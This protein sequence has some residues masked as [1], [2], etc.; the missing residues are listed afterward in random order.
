[1]FSGLPLR[2]LSRT[3]TSSAPAAS[4]PTAAAA[5]SAVIRILPDA[6]MRKSEDLVRIDNTRDSLDISA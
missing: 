3:T 1:M 4:S 5:T 2:W 6:Q